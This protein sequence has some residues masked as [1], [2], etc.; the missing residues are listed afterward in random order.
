MRIGFIK[1]AGLAFAV[2]LRIAGAALGEPVDVA[3]ILAIDSSSSVSMDEYYL[4]LEGYS[5]AFSHPD[6][7]K[8]IRSGPHRSIAV[9]L[10]EWSGERDQ[11]INFPWRRLDDS[12][13]LSRFA[14]ELVVAPRL[15]IGGE[16]AVGAAIDYASRLFEQS[17]FEGARRVI[18][19]SGD[20]TSNRGRPANAARDDAVARG[21]VINGLAIVDEEPELAAYYRNAVVGGAGA[22]VI[23]AQ[24]YQDF[25]DAILKKLVRE[26]THVAAAELP[27]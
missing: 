22:F 23:T 15:V 7:A 9:T 21:I 16:T 25:A 12:E 20:G 8:A 18:D 26:I 17:G 11:M 27:R 1:R 10:F 2:F 24:S 4:Q 19:I 5:T 13:S 3:L 6:L 14:A